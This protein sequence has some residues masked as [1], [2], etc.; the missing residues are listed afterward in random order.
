MGLML[1]C[2]VTVEASEPGSL[3]RF[4]NPEATLST[5]TAEGNEAILALARDASERLLRVRK[6]LQ[7]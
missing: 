2:N 7:S 5:F 1:L 6:T 3:V 4:I